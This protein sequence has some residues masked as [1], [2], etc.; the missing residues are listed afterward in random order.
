[1][2][3]HIKAGIYLILILYCSTA[4]SLI[5]VPK[6]THYV[7]D[8]ANVISAQHEHALNGILQELEQKT[9]VQ[10]IILTINTTKG[11]PINQL[12]LRLAHDQWHLG[13]KGKDNGF[14]FVIA[15]K[16]HKYFFAPGYGL[17]GIV[18]DVICSRTGR[19]I[20]RPMLKAGRISE[21]IYLANMDIIKRISQ[22][23]N[24]QL[25]GTP[26]TDTVPD[27]PR[28]RRTPCCG[29][30][31]ILILLIVLFGGGRGGSG[32]LLMLPFIMGSGRSYG[33]GYGSSGSFGGGSFGGGF[34]GFGGGMG[35]G[36]GG[37]GAGG[38]W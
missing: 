12:S 21:G 23:N 7:E 16:D 38:S 18:P 31:P 4:W 17:E 1:M 14:L 32:L 27:R 37:G 3:R 34:G 11:E 36:F 2:Q 6:P 5:Q 24:V 15:I 22:A 28:T 30:W 33:G 29:F 9:T 26:K 8:H 20:L 35:G 13:H 25:T 10:Y 19:N